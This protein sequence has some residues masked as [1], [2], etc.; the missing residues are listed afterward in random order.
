MNENKILAIVCSIILQF[1]ST[2][3]MNCRIKNAKNSQN[4][5]AHEAHTGTSN[6]VQEAV[7]V[8]GSYKLS[9]IHQ[10][11]FIGNSLSLSLLSAIYYPNLKR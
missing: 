6:L 1:C 7:L 3:S 11:S 9:T 5:T 2:I 8:S 4:S 10:I